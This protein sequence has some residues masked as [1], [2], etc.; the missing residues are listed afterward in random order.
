MCSKYA[1]A[2]MNLNTN[3]YVRIAIFILR[4]NG[5]QEEVHF[6]PLFHTYLLFLHKDLVLD[7]YDN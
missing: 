2:A 7:V 5:Q 4:F 1:A 6:H 3:I